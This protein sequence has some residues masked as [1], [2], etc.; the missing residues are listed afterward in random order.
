MESSFKSCQSRVIEW[1]LL[2]E[3]HQLRVIDWKLLI[4]CLWLRVVY[5]ELSESFLRVVDQCWLRVIKSQVTCWWWL[6]TVTNFTIKII[7]TFMHYSLL[8]IF[9]IASFGIFNKKIIFLVLL[10]IWVIL[11]ILWPAPEGGGRGE[12]LE[13]CNTLFYELRFFFEEWNGLQEYKMQFFLWEF[14]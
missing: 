13:N 9:L 6:V 7:V 5:Q 11:R 3:R 10:Y 14:S 12:V 2:I 8:S 1:V 4:E